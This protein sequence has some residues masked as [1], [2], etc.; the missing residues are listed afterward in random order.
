M[1]WASHHRLSLR[2]VLLGAAFAVVGI[3]AAL[4]AWQDIY[5]IAMRDQEASHVFLVPVVAAYLVWVRR[6]RMRHVRVSGT[7]I[8]PAFI[9]AGWLIYHVG[10]AK[11]WQSV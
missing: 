11:Y 1:R 5:H 2:R 8:G 3:L 9:A 10:D 6:G 7:W 4:D